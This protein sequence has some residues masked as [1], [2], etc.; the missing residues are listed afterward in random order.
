M[1]KILLLIVIIL[2]I[3]MYTQYYYKSN[4]DYN[5]LQTYL[6]N[7]NGNV[8]YEK[9]PIVIY[10]KLVNPKQLL[11]TLFKYTYASQYNVMIQETNPV[12]LICK[13]TVI[14]NMVG[15][16]TINIISPKYKSAVAYKRRKGYAVSPRPLSEYASDVQ[17]ITVKLQKQQVL[18]MPTWWAVQSN[19]IFEAICIDDMFSMVLSKLIAS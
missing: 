6:D 3:T 16:I 7:V 13:Y 12:M 11:T 1:S 4:S 19:D 14:Y 10:D 17:Y 9:Y 18:I 5:I 15:P 8:L 2:V